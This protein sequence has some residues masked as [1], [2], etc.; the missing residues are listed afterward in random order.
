MKWPASFPV[1]LG[2]LVVLA[3][4]IVRI[5]FLVSVDN[6]SVV[7]QQRGSSTYHDAYDYD[8]LAKNLLEHKIYGYGQR[9]SSYRAPG[10]PWFLAGIYAVFGPVPLAVRII[11]VLLGTRTCL[12][13]FLMA[14]EL[15]PLVDEAADEPTADLLTQ[16]MQ[17]H[18]KTAWMLRSMLG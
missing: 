11:Q 5:I 12:L 4:L 14:R 7:I 3:A 16:R 15:F 17:V 9:S 10:Y 8:R 18:E 6:T 13:L 2:G 1:K